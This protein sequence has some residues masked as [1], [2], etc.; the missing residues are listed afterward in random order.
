MAGV[1]SPEPALAP[2]T[3]PQEQPDAVLV[4]HGLRKTYDPDVAPVQAL[5]GADLTLAPGEFVAL[6][7]PS[8]TG[9]STLL[10]ILAGLE[11]ADDGEVWLMGRALSGLT[12]KERTHLRRRHVGIVFQF[13]NL[14]DDMTAQENV[15]LAAMVAG[16]SKREAGARAAELLDL[17]GLLDKAANTPPTLSGGQR[18]RLAIARALANQPTVLLADE[19]TG[20]LDSRGGAEIV[21]LLSRLHARGQTILLVTHNHD[22]AAAADRVLT[23]SDGRITAR[24]DVARR[25]GSAA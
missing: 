9:K 21:E 20:A 11:E 24:G 13:F 18:Q 12:E 7:G 15:A 1:S 17:L 16:A 10:N 6:M 3:P 4:A 25:E 23:M 14:I 2:V 22:V 5:R 8:G 19:P